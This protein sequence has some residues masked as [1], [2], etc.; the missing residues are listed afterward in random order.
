LVRLKGF[1]ELT[2]VDEASRKF[3]Q[4][5][6]PKKLAFTTIPLKEALGRITAEDIAAT[7]DL[8]PFNRSAVDGYA[9]KAKDTFEATQFKPTTLKLI[10]KEA[11]T[12]GEAKAL[13]TGHPIPR[14]ADSVVMLEHT[15]KKDGKIEVHISLTPSANVSTKGEDVK[16]GE[17][18]VEAGTKLNPFQLGLLASLGISKVK[19]VRKPKI[20]VLATGD[21][22]TGLDEQ[23]K[24]NKIIEANSIILSSMCSEAGAEALSLGIAKD[25]ERQIEEKILEGL[26]KA[27]VVV[28]TGG[29]SVGAYDLVPKAVENIQPRSIIVHGVAMR[30]GMPT[31][32]AVVRGKP[33]LILSGNPVAAAVGFEMFARPLIKRL[34]CVD[35]ERARLKARL[36]RNVAGVLGRRVFLRVK[37]AER[38]GELLA[39]PI[40]A[41]GSGVV[42]TLTKAS[43]YV[44]IP[45]DREGLRKD[46]VVTVHFLE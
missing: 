7:R 6:K 8:P 9:L 44:L 12:D 29:T 41:K 15:K 43:G 4:A 21:E 10:Q 16:K 26:E 45:E 34:L 25:D 28:T 37:V 30:P 3:F 39:E 11:I 33:V 17:L 18:V 32:L 31:A 20:A 13:W 23:L 2:P 24:P 22:L 40:S 1:K 46:E 42:S 36:T 27:D 38:D 14:G 35:E 19:V 5:L